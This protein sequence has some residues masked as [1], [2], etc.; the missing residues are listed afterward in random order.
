MAALVAWAKSLQV[1]FAVSIL[2]FIYAYSVLAPW[3]RN[4]VGRTFVWK[5]VC[6]LGLLCTGFAS[7]WLG[8]PAEVSLSLYVA[9]LAGS[10]AIML[11][12]SVV[13]IRE[14]Y[15]AIQQA[16]DSQ[17]VIAALEAQLRSCRARVAA[18]LPAQPIPPMPRTLAPFVR[19]VLWL[20]QAWS[21]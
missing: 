20:R 4:P 9:G 3:W 15:L 14:R 13:F 7:L 16:S 2:V 17:A 12:R 10:T 11:W 19:A 21:R 8:L 18:G 6:L 5:D 1:A